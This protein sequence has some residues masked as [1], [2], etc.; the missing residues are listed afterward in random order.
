MLPSLAAIGISTMAILAIRRAHAEY[1]R[2]S[3]RLGSASNVVTPRAMSCLIAP[4]TSAGW[5]GATSQD[6]SHETWIPLF[7]NLIRV[8]SASAT[9]LSFMSRGERS[10]EH[11][12]E[13]QSLMRTSYAV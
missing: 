4:S 1:C 8:Q 5:L 9:K 6:G 7:S 2:T 3:F 12:S 10:E 13:L 11:T